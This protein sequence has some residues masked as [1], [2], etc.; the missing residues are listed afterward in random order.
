MTKLKE[1]KSR[2]ETVRTRMNFVENKNK[3]ENN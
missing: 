2:Y 1:I 3:N